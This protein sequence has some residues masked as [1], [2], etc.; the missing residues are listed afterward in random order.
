M[1]DDSSG[2]PLSRR[3]PGATNRPKPK[4]RIAP[5]VLPEELVGRL[6]PKQATAET[7]AA[8]PKRISGEVPA[9]PERQVATV[10]EDSPEASATWFVVP[11]SPASPVADSDDT[12]QPIPVIAATGEA[13]GSV[14]VMMDVRKE[15]LPRRGGGSRSAGS[16]SG[17]SPRPGGQSRSAKTQ[18]ANRTQAP[19]IQHADRTQ[20]PERTQ[21][22]GKPAPKP[23]AVPVPLRK[24]SPAQR[25]T[26]GSWRRWAAR[27]SQAASRSGPQ[28]QGATELRPLFRESLSIEEMVA[29]VRAQDAGR[30]AD[31]SRRYRVVAAVLLVVVVAT[32]LVVVVVI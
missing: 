18:L 32:A 22:P 7:T 30:R 11:D 17:A 16:R 12:T 13:P 3:V 31:Q 27:L 23:A 14:K 19:E 8:P 2:P 21:L 24:P 15:Q 10:A 6:R 26:G 4:M 5:P 29:A 20:A 9:K 25:R 28:Q 1:A